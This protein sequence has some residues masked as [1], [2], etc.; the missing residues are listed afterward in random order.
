MKCF[1]YIYILQLKL[2]IK[3][4]RQ[5]MSK[6]KIKSRRAGKKSEKQSSKSFSPFPSAPGLFIIPD[7]LRSP[8][9]TKKTRRPFFLQIWLMNSIFNLPQGYIFPKY[10]STWTSIFQTRVQIAISMKSLIISKR[11]SGKSLLSF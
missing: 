4:R 11:I 3:V 7:F 6:W 10:Y 1:L 5:W 8:R 9:A 2:E